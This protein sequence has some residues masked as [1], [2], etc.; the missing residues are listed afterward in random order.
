MQFERAPYKQWLFDLHQSIIV[1]RKRLADQAKAPNDSN[2]LVVQKAAPAQ[3]MFLLWPIPY[4]GG[5]IRQPDILSYAEIAL[6]MLSEIAQ[7]VENDQVGWISTNFQGVIGRY[8][9]E[10]YAQME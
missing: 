6:M 1:A 9:Q 7:S 10:I 4:F 5:R 2:G 8:L 3:K